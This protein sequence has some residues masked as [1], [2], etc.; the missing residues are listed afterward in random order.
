MSREQREASVMQ[1]GFQDVGLLG[2]EGRVFD[3]WVE[4]Y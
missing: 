2:E 1:L 3:D 4:G